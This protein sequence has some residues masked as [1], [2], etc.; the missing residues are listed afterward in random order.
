MTTTE[1][2]HELV[3]QLADEKTTEALDYLEGLSSPRTRRVPRSWPRL[4]GDALRSIEES[5]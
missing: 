2:M 5:S 3:D 4:S 1:R